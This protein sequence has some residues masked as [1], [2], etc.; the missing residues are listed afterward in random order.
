[1]HCMHLCVAHAGTHHTETLTYL[2]VFSVA[3]ELM[4]GAGSRSA[5]KF[6]KLCA[7]QSAE[8]QF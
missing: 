1:M 5:G 8:R 7:A 2:D 3:N 4:N 6:F